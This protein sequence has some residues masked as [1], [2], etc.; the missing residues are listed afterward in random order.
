MLLNVVFNLFL[1]ILQDMGSPHNISPRLHPAGGESLRSPSASSLSDSDSEIRRQRLPDQYDRHQRPLH[2]NNSERQHL[3]RITRS[4]NSPNYRGDNLIEK[5]QSPLKAW[6]SPQN[7]SPNSSQRNSPHS[8]II[9]P[10][11]DCIVVSDYNPEEF[12]T[13]GGRQHLELPLKEDDKVRVTGKTNI[14][15]CLYLRSNM[16]IRILNIFVIWFAMLEMSSSR[17]LNVVI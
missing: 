3:P 1:F 11:T 6:Q 16:L 15:V 14:L 10:N 4:A 9:S 5:D 13:S 12:S 8:F 17:I 2:P 7:Q